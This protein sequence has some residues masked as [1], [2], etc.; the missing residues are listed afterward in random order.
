MLIY[1]DHQYLDHLHKEDVYELYHLQMYHVDVET[2][3]KYRNK[4]LLNKISKP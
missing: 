3:K 2:I 4:F 1:V